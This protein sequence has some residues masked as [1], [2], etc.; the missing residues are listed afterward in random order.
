MKKYLFAAL[1]FAGMSV[2]AY[3]QTKYKVVTVVESII[4]MGLGRSRM[5]ETKTDLDVRAATTERT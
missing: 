5:I 3:A 2:Q 1:L 4:P